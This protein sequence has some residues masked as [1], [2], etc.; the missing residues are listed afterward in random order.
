MDI[1]FAHPWVTNTISPQPNILPKSLEDPFTNPPHKKKSVCKPPYPS[2][3]SEHYPNSSPCEHIGTHTTTNDYLDW[4]KHSPVVV[5]Q[6][7][8]QTA[9]T[10]MP[11][12]TDKKRWRECVSPWGQSHTVFFFCN[13]LFSHA[14]NMRPICWC[15][16]P[17]LHGLLFYLSQN[18]AR[19][20]NTKEENDVSFIAKYLCYVLLCPDCVHRST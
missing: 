2:F 16:W 8:Y 12:E 10:N 7:S 4:K 9:D 17:K 1:L 14:K 20:K 18:E 15:K 11:T 5:C 19:K 6:T 13:L 3:S